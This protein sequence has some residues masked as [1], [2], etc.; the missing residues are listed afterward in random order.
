MNPATSK[1]LEWITKFINVKIFHDNDVEDRKFMKTKS[2][3]TGYVSVQAL[4]LNIKSAIGNIAAGITS[5]AVN[6]PHKQFLIGLHRYMKN[7]AKIRAI[8]RNCNIGTIIDDIYYTEGQRVSGEY[9][10]FMF[11]PTEYAEYINQGVAFAGLLTESEYNMYDSDG[12]PGPSGGI[13]EERVGFLETQTTSFHGD[14]GFNRPLYSSNF[15]LSLIGQFYWGWYIAASEQ[16]TGREHVNYFGQT[17]KGVLPT[18]VDGLKF[19]AFRLRQLITPKQSE[20]IIKD[21]Y[22]KNQI[23][24]FASENEANEYAEKLINS[25]KNIYPRV[26]KAKDGKFIVIT[27]EDELSFWS[28]MAINTLL[29]VDERDVNVSDVNRKNWRKLVKMLILSALFKSVG[30]LSTILAYA[31]EHGLW[32]MDDDEIIRLTGKNWFQIAAQNANYSYIPGMISHKGTGGPKL[33]YEYMTGSEKFLLYWLFKPTSFIGNSLSADIIAPGTGFLSMIF[34]VMKEGAELGSVRNWPSVTLL[35]SWLSAIANIGNTFTVTDPG[36]GKAY[37]GSVSLYHLARVAPGLGSYVQKTVYDIYNQVSG[38]YVKGMILG[39]AIND[40]RSSPGVLMA[41]GKIKEDYKNDPVLYE[42]K[43]KELKS[44]IV[45][46]IAQRY[47]IYTTMTEAEFADKIKQ[48]L[49]GGT[50]K[51]TYKSEGDEIFDDMI[52]DLDFDIKN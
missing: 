8:M 38:N 21:A 10:G 11:K 9:I 37:G 42:E 51:S 45:K 35:T 34:N 7:P 20:K 13:S 5:D 32:D 52:E 28:H 49:I 36:T 14:Y 29:A 19:T 39:R 12:N 15:M 25:A 30:I 41:L 27:E 31:I 44:I 18:V 33:G 1:S 24:V 26:A 46:A 2:F 48:S 3:L 6:M 50:V 47:E 16:W 17:R 40:V 43:V 22:E 23:K 4:G